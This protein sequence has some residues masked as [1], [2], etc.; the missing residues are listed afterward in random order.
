MME[1]LSGVAKHLGTEYWFEA[2]GRKDETYAATMENRRFFL[3]PISACEL[4]EETEWQ[5]CTT[6]TSRTNLSLRNGS[7]MSR[8]KSGNRLITHRGSRSDGSSNQR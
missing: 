3:Y 5:R 2:E 8:T 4:A 6:S 1:A 7:S